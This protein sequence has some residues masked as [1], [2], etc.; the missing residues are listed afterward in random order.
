MRG[1]GIL[2][3]KVLDMVYGVDERLVSCLVLDTFEI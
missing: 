1:I 3:A 2:D